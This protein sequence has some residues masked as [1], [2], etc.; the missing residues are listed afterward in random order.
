ML[1]TAN[2][3]VATATQVKERNCAACGVTFQFISKTLPPKICDDCRLERRRADDRVRAEAKRRAK[4]IAPLKGIVAPCA[5]CGTE[6]V[7]TNIK[8][9]CCAAC[10]ERRMVARTRR[11]SRE[12][13]ATPEGRKYAQNWQRDKRRSDP[14]WRVSSHMRVLMHRALK[15]KKQGKS[16]RKFVDYSLSEL[17]SHLEKRFQPGMTWENYGKW[18]I[19]HIIPRSSVKDVDSPEFKKIWRLENLQPLWA[20]DNIRKNARYDH[21]FA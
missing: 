2:R 4:G 1:T 17:M 14:A 20:L 11:L 18:H 12:K 8:H 15:K 19:D 6:I 21:A 5:D 9:V 13:N 10:G 3:D 7:R 16:W